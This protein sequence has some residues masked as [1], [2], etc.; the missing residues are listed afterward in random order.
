M[1][2][3]PQSTSSSSSSASS[4]HLVSICVPGPR[5][6][7]SCPRTP[8][9]TPSWRRTRGTSKGH[10]PYSAHIDGCMISYLTEQARNGL[11][12]PSLLL[13]RIVQPV[14]LVSSP[15]KD[16]YNRDGRHERGARLYGLPEHG[17]LG[18][19]RVVGTGQSGIAV[20]CSLSR[21]TQPRV[22]DVLSIIVLVL[23]LSSRQDRLDLPLAR[24][25]I[26]VRCSP[27]AE[28]SAPTC[29]PAPIVATA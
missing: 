22:Q 29:A 17:G 13:Y 12:L 20:G 27:L 2:I 19:E 24:G 10:M 4:L 15:A 6:A 8:T 21:L 14:D 23:A 16:I 1:G 25:H 26:L 11:G 7:S 5:P 18:V 3:S 9:T 28:G